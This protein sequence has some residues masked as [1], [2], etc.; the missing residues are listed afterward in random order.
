MTVQR[1]KPND[2][3][4][5]L[6]NAEDRTI[7][8]DPFGNWAA[9]EWIH[10]KDLERYEKYKKLLSSDQELA[11]KF[12]KLYELILEKYLLN[13]E[14][15]TAREYAASTLGGNLRFFLEY[16]DDVEPALDGIFAM[17]S[18]H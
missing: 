8:F 2:F 5:R 3:Q 11:S 4:N 7:N 10:K 6:C 17:V 9:E 12:K 18:S 15:A 16:Y 13:F 14:S 1:I